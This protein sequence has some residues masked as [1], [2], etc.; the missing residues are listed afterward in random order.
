MAC[1]CTTAKLAHATASYT[2]G[3]ARLLASEE[4]ASAA[5]VSAT[6]WLQR[7]RP[8]LALLRTIAVFTHAKPVHTFSQPARKVAT[9][10]TACAPRLST[11]GERRLRW[12]RARWHVA[13]VSVRV[14]IR[15]W[16][17]DLPSC[18]SRTALFSPSLLLASVLVACLAEDR[19]VTT[20]F[21]LALKRL[22]N[23]VK[24]FPEIRL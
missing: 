19:L 11:A 22:R 20:V 15:I 1:F 8:A 24:V 4:G 21:V 5:C 13:R 17:I 16:V 2:L 12:K 14:Q 7:R 6:S 10:E 3:S 9:E 23:A 18:R